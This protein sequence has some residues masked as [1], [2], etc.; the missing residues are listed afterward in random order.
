ML[1]I[2]FFIFQIQI[3]VRESCEFREESCNVKTQLIDSIFDEKLSND[4]FVVKKKGGM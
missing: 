2:Y 1:L 4:K 3:Y